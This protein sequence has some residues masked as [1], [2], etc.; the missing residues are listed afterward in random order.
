M[1]PNKWKRCKYYCCKKLSYNVLG[2][3]YSIKHPD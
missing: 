3:K 2:P 1:T